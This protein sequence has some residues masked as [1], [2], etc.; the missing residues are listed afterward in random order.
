[1]L[2]YWNR[3]T[4]SAAVEALN[5]AAA[6]GYHLHLVKSAI[7]PA[8]NLA[9]ADVD[10]CDF[11]GYAALL[12][13]DQIETYEIAAQK[14][15]CLHVLPNVFFTTG[16]PPTPGND[17][18]GWYITDASGPPNLIAYYG[19]FANPVSMRNTLDRV[20]IELFLLLQS[21]PTSYGITNGQ[22]N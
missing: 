21:P 14:A 2:G 16:D 11:A 17:V 7:T 13:D 1:M 4:I 18:Y 19:N 22:P 8:Y 6:T 15:R 5:T 12:L 10:E 3:G 9:I 20:M